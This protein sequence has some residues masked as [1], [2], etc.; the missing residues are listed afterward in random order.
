MG[1]LTG[2]AL[3]LVLL[4]AVI[5]AVTTQAVEGAQPA[6]QVPAY[7]FHSAW[8]L[9]L[10]LGLGLLCGPLAALY[11]ALVY[12]F[13][14]AFHA[15]SAVP[16]WLKPALAGL[17]VGVVGLALP[18]V[19]GVGYASIERVLHGEGLAIGLLLALVFAKLILNPVSL[20]G[21][22]QGGTFAPSLFIGAML[23]GAY[24]AVIVQF[25]PSLGIEPPAFAMVG[26]AAVLASMAHAPLTAILL[27]FEMTRDYH[28]IL[29]L[30][31]AVSVSLFI[32][33]RL[34]HDSVYLHGLARKG[35]RLERGRD[36]D[37]LETLKVSEVMQTAPT[38]VRES[39]TLAAASAVLLRTRHHG[40]PVLNLADELVGI[41][42][43][44]D[45]D[46]ML[47][48]GE[49][50]ALRT[51][52]EV[53]TREMLTALPDE[54]LNVALRRMSAR[55]I[56]RLPVVAPDNPRQLLGVLRRSDVVRAY[57]AALVRRTELRHRAQ[58]VRLGALSNLGGGAVVIEEFHIA[59][60]AP[61]AHQLLSAVPWPR[62]CVIAT[63]RREG[64]VL[65]P[66]GDTLLRPGDVL[67]VALEGVAREVVLQLVT[68]P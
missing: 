28:I 61:C 14:D 57:E 10:Y 31:F 7:A 20:A 37:V 39:E 43:V 36:V 51:V 13:H 62:E 9:P 40:L 41:V 68:P 15:L 17:V 54:T 5:S 3:G 11:I 25:F 50:A 24:G 12:G 32:T 56:G 49:A 46:R 1:E 16:G 29:P 26:M 64:Q 4:S 33:R 53:C 2:S 63:I 21:G 44:Q 22:F 8:E 65:L 52:G 58:Q 19:M 18:Q 27:L 34:R 59:P 30:M 48:E 35:V 42:T 6:F 45:I 67:V 66:R 47:E 38:T 55:D 23:G 60:N